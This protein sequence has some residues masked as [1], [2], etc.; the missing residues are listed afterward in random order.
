MY[1]YQNFS[2]RIKAVEGSGSEGTSKYVGEG[3]T[4]GVFMVVFLHAR[5]YQCAHIRLLMRGVGRHAQLLMSSQRNIV[6]WCRIEH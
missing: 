4:Y 6:I 5:T 3:V 2:L 1:L